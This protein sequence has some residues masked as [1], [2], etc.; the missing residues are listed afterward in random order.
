MPAVKSSARNQAVVATRLHKA[1]EAEH[2]R[3]FIRSLRQLLTARDRT[4]LLREAI[5]ILKWSVRPKSVAILT[6]HGSDH[7]FAIAA[8]EGVV[9]KPK[10]STAPS[11]LARLLARGLRLRRPMIIP[12]LIVPPVTKTRRHHRQPSYARGMLVPITGISRRFGLL[13]LR[14]RRDTPF[15]AADARVAGAVADLLSLALKRFDKAEQLREHARRYR[16]L[17]DGA[18][19]V[20]FRASLIP[21]PRIGYVSPSIKILTGYTA[22]EF[23]ANPRLLTRLIHAEDMPDLLAK[24]EHPEQIVGRIRLRLIGKDGRRSWVSVASVPIYDRRARLI[25]V[26]GSACEIFDPVVAGE[27]FRAASESMEA[28]LQGRRGET[29]LRIIVHH[30]RYVLDADEVLIAAAG[31]GK[32]SL[33]I[34]CHDGTNLR[35]HRTG[36]TVSRTDPLIGRALK[37]DRPIVTGRGIATAIPWSSGKP[38]VLIAG[39]VA[40]DEVHLAKAVG[41]VERF[42]REIG[43]TLESMRV[44]QSY[45]RQAIQEDR[46][47][48]ARELHDGIVQSLYALEMVLQMNA[49]SV[50]DPARGRVSQA[51][52]GIREAIQDIQQYVF[53]LEPSVLSDGGLANSLQRLAVEFEASS[54]I[55]VSLHSE[56]D[57]VASLEPVATHVLQIVREALSNVR[58]HSHARSA[59]VTIR[60]VGR[61]IKLEINDDG[62]GF[63][64]EAAQ[65]LGMRNLRTRARLLGGKLELKSDSK[66]GSLVRLTVPSAARES[67]PDSVSLSS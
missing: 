59:G 45:L 30:L 26:Q 24:L 64:Q 14:S 29:V 22:S 12:D 28:I 65:G 15:G 54:R 13:T 48:I 63:S 49:A 4:T 55:I 8:A 46:S 42:A 37:A 31:G 36:G 20:I 61:R 56:P 11:T 58:R 25:G 27:Q 5:V 1:L 7:A 34:I 2:H 60:T 39:G 52:A 6:P 43:T 33:T 41:A 51:A 53:D 38:G 62:R 23:Y 18:G 35:G 66:H 19:E 17:V 16:R 47:R 3:A 50:P 32:S 21:E 9:W 40:G 57:A 44:H 67:P 10:R